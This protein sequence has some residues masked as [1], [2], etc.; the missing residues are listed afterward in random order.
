MNK[1]KPVKWIAI[2]LVGVVIGYVLP[3]NSSHAPVGAA[4]AAA[5]IWTC[6]MHPQ[7][8][9]PKAGKCPLCGMDLIPL[10]SSSNET[11][12]KAQLQLSPYAQQLAGIEVTPVRRENLTRQVRMVGKIEPDETRQKTI[13]AWVPG[14]LDRLYVDYTGVKV[15]KG[16]HLVYLYSPDLIAAQEELIQSA[17]T[18]RSYNDA[19]VPMVR[20]RAIALVETSREKLRLLG[21]TPEQIANVESRGKPDTHL[22]IYSPISGI[23]LEK[24]AKEGMYV[25]TGSPIYQIADLSTVWL[26]LDAYESDLRWLHYGQGVQFETEAHPGEPFEGRIAFI[27]PVLDPKT[28]TV[29]IRVNVPNTDGRLKPGMFVRAIVEASTSSDGRVFAPELAGKFI[30]PM[31][32]EILKDAPGK[33]DVCGMDLVPIEEYGFATSVATNAAPLVI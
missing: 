2:A 15:E 30:S 20:E 5:T 14:R 26:K 17:L 27:D 7:I 23:V 8:K 1:I 10:K 22:N 12:G 13:T 11:L 19:T 32:P 6:S 28:R 31:H 33:C 16:D 29:K 3:K 18:V 4:N 21:L 24:H 9:L 25:Q